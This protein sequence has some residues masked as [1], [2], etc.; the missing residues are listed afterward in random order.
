MKPKRT[1]RII[2]TILLLGVATYLALLHLWSKT[3]L[4]P[5]TPYQNA[6]Q[7]ISEIRTL[8]DFE[9]RDYP[10]SGREWAQY[11]SIAKRMRITPL[12]ITKTA[13]HEASHGHPIKPMF[14]LFVLLEVCF[15][16]HSE[17]Q[18]VG[19]RFGHFYLKANSWNYIGPPYDA[20]KDFERMLKECEWREL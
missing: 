1:I 12:E 17:N 10:P 3:K 8:P 11:I 5:P 2:V 7:L 6:D 14:K 18:P 15:D 19:H 20:S 13:L 4:L 16:C 9:L